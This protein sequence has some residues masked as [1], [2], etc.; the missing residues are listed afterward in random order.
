MMQRG[1]WVGS[2]DL[3]RARLGTYATLLVNSGHESI[4][5][6]LRSGSS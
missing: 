5:D 3:E 1:S 6:M 4:P 2:F